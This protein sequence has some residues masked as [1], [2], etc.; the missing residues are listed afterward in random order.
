M[1]NKAQSI[2]SI[3]VKDGES[4]K[5]DF[6]SELI[7]EG[8]L[9][10]II[11]NKIL[12]EF[13]F[14]EVTKNSLINVYFDVE[15]NKIENQDQKIVKLKT[16]KGIFESSLVVGADG[17]YSKTRELSNF[18]YFYN[19]YNQQAL[20][21]NISHQRSHNALAVEYFFPSGPLALLPMKNNKQKM[22]SV[23]WTVENSFQLD[24]KRKKLSSRHLKINTTVNSVKL[25][26][27][28]SLFF[29]I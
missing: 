1:V 4:N 29:I 28:L 16:N 23:V 10:Y 18:K 27:F 20:V 3:L 19:D 13:V 2:N 24:L 7:S 14:N 22:S 12:K 15:I 9:G 25:K 11:E 8:P 5:I 17:R 26:I 6:D 21:F